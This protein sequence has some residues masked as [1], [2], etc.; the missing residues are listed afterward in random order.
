LGDIEEKDAFELFVVPSSGGTSV[1]INGDLVGGGPIGA[2]ILEFV[3]SPDSSRIAYTATQRSETL[4]LFTSKI[5][6]SENTRVNPDLVAGAFGVADVQWSPDSTRIAY[7]ADQLVLG[8]GI[9]VAKFDGTENVRV[10]ADLPVGGEVSSHAW[11]PDG[12]HIAYYGELRFDERFELFTAKP[13]GSDKVRV[14]GDGGEVENPRGINVFVWSPDSSRIAYIADHRVDSSYELFTSLPDGSG[15][16][17]VNGDLA[18]PTHPLSS[19]DVIDFAWSP[20]AS[21]ISY[22]A[23]QRD[24]IVAELFTSK[25]DGTE[26]SRVNGDLAA[27]GVPSGSVSWSPDSS[28]IVYLAEQRTV[29]LFEWFTGKPDGSENFRVNADLAGD[30]GGGFFPTYGWSPDSSRFAYSA[31]QQADNLEELFIS[32]FNGSNNVRVSGDNSNIEAV[33]W[34]PDSSRIVYVA[35]T[36]TSFE[37]FASEADGSGA[38]APLSGTMVSGGSVFLNVTV[39]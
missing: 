3:W 28:R 36:D 23:N 31:E 10:N 29:D 6:G 12:S 20:D 16:V 30:L 1:K 32:Q 4:E 27:G 37:L 38:P 21:R 9:F 14:S 25:P 5:D 15:N 35:R 7:R 8:R 19:P 13:D 22:V 2:F 17:R 11:S 34:S 18:P 26:N 24:E 33:F 39:R